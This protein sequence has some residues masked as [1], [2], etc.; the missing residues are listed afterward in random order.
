M[1]VAKLLIQE[2]WKLRISRDENVLHNLQVK[3]INFQNEL[4]VIN[5][6]KIPRHVMIPEYITIEM[7]GFFDA[8][9]RAYGACLYIRYITA[10][11][12]MSNL[13]C[14][15]SQVAP[16]KSVS[17]PRLELCRAVLLANLV[18][19]VIESLRIDFSRVMYSTLACIK[20]EVFVANRVGE[21]QT[22]IIRQTRDFSLTGYHI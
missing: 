9:E 6:F 3:W 22:L 21:I 20:W 13:L 14:G 11:K 4:F 2:L 16:V 19:K 10:I 17:L 8:F 15:K 5:E 18:K 1:I 7:H 12:I